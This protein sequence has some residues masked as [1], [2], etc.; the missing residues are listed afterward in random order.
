MNI[1]QF[2]LQQQSFKKVALN[3]LPKLYPCLAVV[4]PATNDEGKYLASSIFEFLKDETWLEA[5]KIK[6]T[7]SQIKTYMRYFHVTNTSEYISAQTKTTRYSCAVPIVLAAYRQTRGIKYSSWDTEDPYFARLLGPTM[8]PLLDFELPREFSVEELI[9]LRP[10]ALPEDAAPTAYRLRHTGCQEFDK[11]PKNVRHMLLQTW[12]YH[13]T[14]RHADMV[15]SL[16]DWDFLPPPL[17][18]ETFAIPA[19]KGRMDLSDW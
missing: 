2:D 16:E 1:F 11:L 17:E 10:L 7:S 13:P 3:Y 19:P 8:Q 14:V 6:F 15:C 9:D 18:G 5:E 4:K 12:I